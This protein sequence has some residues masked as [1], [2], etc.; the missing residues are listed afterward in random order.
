M[1]LQ[2]ITLLGIAGLSSVC[3][4]AAT[5]SF[6]ASDTLPNNLNKSL[7]L[8]KFDSSLGTLT[9]VNISYT[10]NIAGANV[11]MDNDSNLSQTATASVSNQ[12]I[13]FS[14]SLGSNS[15]KNS[16][17]AA[18]ISAPLLGILETH[19]FVLAAT[20]GD[21][22]GAFNNTGAADYS[23]WSPGTLSASAGGDVG[24]SYISL[25]GGGGTFNFTI[26][27]LYSTSASF[28]GSQGYFQGNTPSGDA[29]ATVTY[30][31]TPTAIPEPSGYSV[32]AGF[33][34]LG[35]TICLRRRERR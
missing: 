31:Y 29:S 32:L 6:T 26:K 5:V 17:N 25:Y 35:G 34:V 3:T 9:G 2:Y 19:D 7:T 16:G 20:S 22:V 1:K 4:H 11:Q 15:L 21:A 12:V 18:L 14:S 28:D 23:N 8:S 10:V 13:S 30:T 27:A 33:V 24:S